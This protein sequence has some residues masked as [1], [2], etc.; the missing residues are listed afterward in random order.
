[1]NIL[2]KF[3]TAI[4]H[5]DVAARVYGEWAEGSTSR[6][7]FKSW[8]AERGIGAELDLHQ[9]T[10]DADGTPM[11]MWTPG[12]RTVEK[13]NT[14]GFISDGSTREWAG[15]KVLSHTDSECVVAFPFGA[16][17]QLGFYRVA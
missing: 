17:T 15:A 8:I 11:Y 12:V 14:V 16:D 13:I 1:M 5:K 3:L 10:V 4:A 9:I 2:D 6:K 7:S